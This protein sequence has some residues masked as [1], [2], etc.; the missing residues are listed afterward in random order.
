[1][2]FKR[3]NK[4]NKGRFGVK[5]RKKITRKRAG[6]ATIGNVLK[7]IKMM[8]RTI[9]TK[10]GVQQIT[11]GDQY[12]HNTLNVV[13]STFMRTS[14]GVSDNENSQG[15]RIGDKLTLVGVKF[16]LMLELNERYSDVTFRLMVIRSA[17]GDTPT[18]ATLWQGASGNKML[19]TFNTER[20]S[21][22]HTKYV[23]IKA[24]N[25]GIEPTGIQELGG[26]RAIGPVQISR[27]T[28]IVKFFIPGKRFARNGIL[29]YEGST[30]QVKFFDYHF[31]IYAYSNYSTTELFNVG[32]LNDCFIKMHYKDA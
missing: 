11:D 29:Q 25:L 2:V 3:K 5:G 23:K 22:L 13:S 24:P 26:G 6:S 1:M 16:T 21:V 20:Y 7:K 10:S 28:K 14:Q 17:K 4:T 8:T 12:V 19:D 32:R 18:T 31:C 30:A 15:Q 9:E 27:A